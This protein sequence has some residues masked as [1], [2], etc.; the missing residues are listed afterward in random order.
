[1]SKILHWKLSE[2][3]KWRGRKNGVVKVMENGE[4]KLLWEM[5]ILFHN[6]VEARRLDIKLVSKTDNKIMYSCGHY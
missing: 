6:I 1:M 3:T 2:S 5:N 4:V